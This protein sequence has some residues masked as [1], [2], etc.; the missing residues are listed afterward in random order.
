MS[1]LD[2]E[3]VNNINEDHVNSTI[4]NTHRYNMQETYT[5][6]TNYAG[7]RALPKKLKELLKNSTTD[8][9]KDMSNITS[10]DEIIKMAIEILG[11]IDARLK[12]MAEKVLANSSI[13]KNNISL[14]PSNTPYSSTGKCSIDTDDRIIIDVTANRDPSGIIAVAQNLIDAGLYYEYYRNDRNKD[15]K[16]AT[17]ARNSAKKFIG[18][19]MIDAMAKNPYMNISAEQKENLINTHLKQDFSNIESLEDDVEIFDAF[20]EAHEDE[21]GDLEDINDE[22]LKRALDNGF[23]CTE[24]PEIQEKIEDRIED[25][26]EDKNKTTS[27]IIGETLE[28][29]VALQTIENIQDSPQ[30]DPI[31][32]LIEGAVNGYSVQQITNKTPEELANASPELIE[33]I[34][35]GELTI[36]GDDKE[37][38]VV[39]EM[40]K[41]MPPVVND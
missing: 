15:E 30:A 29:V 36:D 4:G 26:A 9:L 10:K 40:L 16:R 32:A 14:A 24:H 5:A 2:I 41:Q 37:N 35:K 21:F 6:F 12:T 22:T 1:D 33:S 7:F 13:D 8:Q 28:T 31:K 3:N 39:M 27:Y 23:E 17:F 18:Y 34:A 25:I 19:A 20:I 38:E 11:Q